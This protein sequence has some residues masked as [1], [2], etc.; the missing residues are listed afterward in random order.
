MREHFPQTA[1][2]HREEILPPDVEEIYEPR[3]LEQEEDEDDETE[4]AR[5]LSERKKRELFRQHR[6]PGHPQPTELARALRHAG[7]R[8]EAIQFVLKELRCPTCEARPLPLPPRPGMLPRCLRFNQCIDVDLVDLEVRDGTSAKALNV[9][10]WGTGL[11]IV[12]PWWTNYTAKT[13]MKEFKIAWVEHNGWPEII[14]HDQGPG[15]M[16]NEFQ[17]PAGAAG[18][19]TMPIDSQSPWQNGK[20][21]RAGQSFKH[22]LW[23]LDEECRIE[24]KTEFEAAVAECCDARNRYC[25]R[26]GFSAHQRVFGS[27]LRLPGSLLSDDPIDRQL[28]TADPYTNFHRANEMRT[29]AQRA[30]FKQNSARAVQAAGLARHRSQPRENI[31]AGDTT[32]V[33]SSKNLTGR[34]GWTGSG[35]V[36]AVSPTKTSFWISMRGCL[37]KCSSEQVRKAIDAE[38]L[39]AELSK[40]L[41]TELLKSRQRSGQRGYVDVEVEG[42]PTEEPPANSQ[43]TTQA[44]GDVSQTPDEVLVNN[45]S[46]AAS[47]IPILFPLVSASNY[48]TV[49]PVETEFDSKAQAIVHGSVDAVT[50][51]DSTT[52]EAVEGMAVFDSE[53]QS[54]WV[55]PRPKDKSGVV[56]DELSETDKKKSTHLDSRK[57]TTC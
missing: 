14:V 11:Q 30:L 1:R 26:S 21:E 47:A 32:M 38:W 45:P 8:R 49:L 33:W 19:L 41:A 36:V 9:V 10:C 29:A 51:Q 15:F 54:F 52:F 35:V 34:K 31:N 24:G 4:T 57:S 53:T 13:V 3:H 40:T 6:N 39:G 55:A 18:V 7:A 20:T 46:G 16:G 22:Q 5:P 44:R 50:E 42:Q 56:Y 25:N 43:S 27:S 37:L 23:D 17:N 12:Q 28:L 48:L 2:S